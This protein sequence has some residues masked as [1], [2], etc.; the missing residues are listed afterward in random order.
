MSRARNRFLLSP[1][2]RR[3]N[4]SFTRSALGLLVTSPDASPNKHMELNGME[5]KWACLVCMNCRRCAAR[6]FSHLEPS[7]GL[8]E[9][10]R[11]LVRGLM[12]ATWAGSLAGLG[13][14]G[15][16]VEIWEEM[17]GMSC[18]SMFFQF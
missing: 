11:G 5:W 3:R 18:L 1:L 4:W 8:W 13:N 16:W 17:M 2:H 14:E 12:V 10:L 15:Y 9:D 7:A 6:F